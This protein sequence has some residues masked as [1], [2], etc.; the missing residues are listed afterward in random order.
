[1]ACQTIFVF[2]RHFGFRRLLTCI[3]CFRNIYIVYTVQWWF[4]F[5]ALQLFLFQQSTQ[6][7]V[8]HAKFN[9]WLGC[10]LVLFPF[11]QCKAIK[12]FQLRRKRAPKSSQ[13]FSLL[14]FCGLEH[15]TGMSRNNHAH[16]PTRP[17]ASHA[18]LQ[19]AATVAASFGKRKASTCI[20]WPKLA[21]SKLLAKI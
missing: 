3:N 6:R 13:H 4:N 16:K 8:A 12:P 15:V 7:S 2:A 9:A 11:E 14:P 20:W 19:L 17:L 1:M 18:P 10:A 5:G 21:W